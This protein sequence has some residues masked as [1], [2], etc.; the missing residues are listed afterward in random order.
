[1]RRL[2]EDPALAEK[3]G[4]SRHVVRLVRA[5]T[6]ADAPVYAVKETV[7]EFANREYK[8]LREFTKERLQNM[9]KAKQFDFNP[10]QIFGKFDLFSRRVGKLIELFG[11]IKQF[12]TL[13]KHNLE[14]I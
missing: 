6:D 13:E 11:T 7:S 10:T 3:R 14:N 2:P 12:K 8:V 5:T 4:I 1:M 9:P